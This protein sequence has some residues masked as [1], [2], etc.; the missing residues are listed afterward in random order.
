MLRRATQGSEN[1]SIEVDSRA[2]GPGTMPST[3]AAESDVFVTSNLLPPP[4]DGERSAQQYSFPSLSDAQ[5]TWSLDRCRRCRHSGD[6]A[7]GTTR[8]G[9]RDIRR[10]AGPPDYVRTDGGYIVDH[11]VQATIAVPAGFRS[12]SSRCN[13]VDRANVFAHETRRR[14]LLVV[15]LMTVWYSFRSNKSRT[16]A[17]TGERGP[18]NLVLRNLTARSR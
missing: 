16:I 2:D 8:L 7:T 4:G 13:R 17:S 15:W 10:V 9:H 3:G 12:I 5:P 14:S 6:D 18:G 11:S 1:W